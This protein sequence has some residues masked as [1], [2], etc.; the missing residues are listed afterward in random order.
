MLEYML[1]MNKV[2]HAEAEKELK[3]EMGVLKDKNN[4]LK[5]KHT[6]S[7]NEVG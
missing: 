7:E 6:N 5:R 4:H 3:K 2:M 1:K